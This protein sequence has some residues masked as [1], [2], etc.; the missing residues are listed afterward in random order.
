MKDENVTLKRSPGEEHCDGTVESIVNEPPHQADR[1]RHG[2][3]VMLAAHTVS[4]D[5]KRIVEELDDQYEREQ[6]DDDMVVQCFSKSPI[7]EKMVEK[8]EVTSE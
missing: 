4:I 8:K 1:W 6:D 5:V 2:Q 7:D 3:R